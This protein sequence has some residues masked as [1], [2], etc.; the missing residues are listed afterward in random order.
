L[1]GIQ[2]SSPVCGC[3]IS[4]PTCTSQPSSKHNPQLGAAG[5]RLQAEALACLDGHQADGDILVEGVL[6]EGTP[7]TFGE[8]DRWLLCRIGLV[9]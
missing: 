9:T 6:F 4:S 7:G 5:V 2:I 8:S 3:S 1:A